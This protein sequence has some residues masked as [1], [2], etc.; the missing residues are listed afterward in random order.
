LCVTRNDQAAKLN[1]TD[2]KAPPSAAKNEKGEHGEKDNT[3]DRTE[4][5][6]N[7]ILIEDGEDAAS[8]KTIAA[9][10]EKRNNVQGRQAQDG[11]DE[12]RTAA[13]EAQ[14]AQVA[15]TP[16]MGDAQLGDLEFERGM[17][18]V[19]TTKKLTI[20]KSRTKGSHHVVELKKDTSVEILDV[21]IDDSATWLQVRTL[22]GKR[23]KKG[24]VRP[25]DKSGHLMVKPLPTPTVN[26]SDLLV[27]KRSKKDEKKD[28]VLRE[29]EF[30]NPLTD[31]DTE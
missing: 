19:A 9:A 6:Y 14:P 18:L 24:W 15:R 12:N 11:S 5:L 25:L 29:S 1:D 28:S 10:N 13:P 20:R 30:V 4:Q 17:H 8:L 3:P 22:S 21:A 27:N 2:D 16:Q 31:A 23:A 7:S 26:I